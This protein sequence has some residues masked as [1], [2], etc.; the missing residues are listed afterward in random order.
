[1]T[2]ADLDSHSPFGC[3][4][5]GQPTL[6]R[7]IKLG[8]FAALDQRIALRYTMNGME[9]AETK[10]YLA[11]HLALAGRSDTLFSDD[12]ID[13]IH[14]VS[15]GLPRAVNNL[16]V[17]ALIAAFATN[18]KIVDESSARAAVTEVTTD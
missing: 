16:A 6:R 15:R 11:H 14:Q 13:L 5:V 1:L 2:N 17:Q 9:A 18:K 3:L 12:A 10:T 8:T 4:L 7:K